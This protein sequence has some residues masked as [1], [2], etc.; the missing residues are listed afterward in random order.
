MNI[1]IE[2]EVDIVELCDRVADRFAIDSKL[3]F[4]GGELSIILY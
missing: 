1:G 4:D 2:V 3:R